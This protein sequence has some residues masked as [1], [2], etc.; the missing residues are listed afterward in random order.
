MAKKQRSD[1]ITMQGAAMRA[2]SVQPPAHIEIW[3]EARPF[4]DNVIAECAKVD[5]TAHQLEMAAILA[6]CMCQ[7]VQEQEKA[8]EEGSVI[9]SDKGTPMQNPRI[10]AVHDLQAQVAKLRQGLAINGRA[11]KGE[12]RDVRKRTSQLKA[13]EAVVDELEGDG[14]IAGVHH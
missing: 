13:A 4:W 12:A 2:K 14:L 5:W 10:R 1:S 3:P 9:V 7:L 8:R 6:R 11:V